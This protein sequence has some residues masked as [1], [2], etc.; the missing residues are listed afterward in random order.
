MNDNYQLHIGETIVESA[1]FASLKK[2]AEENVGY[3]EIY[4]VKPSKM[5]NRFFFREKL[6]DADIE[7]AIKLL[8]KGLTR[9]EVAKM[10][11][12]GLSSFDSHVKKYKAEHQIILG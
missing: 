3:Y 5:N 2:I 10:F 7:K 12:V 4:V 9:A 11:H 8:G 1:S 6:T